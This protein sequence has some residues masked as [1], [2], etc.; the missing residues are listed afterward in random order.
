M[1]ISTNDVAPIDVKTDLLSAVG[2]GNIMLQDFLAQRLQITPMPV[3]M[4]HLSAIML[5]CISPVTASVNKGIKTAHLNTG[6]GGLL[7]HHDEVK[8]VIS[9]FDL[10][11]LALSET[12]IEKSQHPN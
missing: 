11:V 3:A 6:N 9:K 5:V 12:W 1:C 10:D 7:Y 4:Y 2:R 8:R